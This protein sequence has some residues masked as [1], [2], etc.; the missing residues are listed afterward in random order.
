MEKTAYF[1]DVPKK[2]HKKLCDELMAHAKVSVSLRGYKSGR[3]A[4]RL[5]SSSPEEFE[6]A[7]AWLRNHKDFGG[8]FTKAGV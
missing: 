2:H 5:W 4:V 3:G 6:K 1:S 7:C 8:A